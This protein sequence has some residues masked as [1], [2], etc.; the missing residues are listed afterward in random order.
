M[1]ECVYSLSLPVSIVSHWWISLKV[2]SL[3]ETG[4]WAVWYM[5]VSSKVGLYHLEFSCSVLVLFFHCV[6]LEIPNTWWFLFSS[7]CEFLRC[8][9]RVQGSSAS[10]WSCSR[11]LAVV[12]IEYELVAVSWAA[13]L[14][15]WLDCCVCMYMCCLI[16]NA[17]SRTAAGV[18][19]SSLKSSDLFNP[20]SFP[21]CLFTCVD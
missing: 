3:E 9:H 12:R 4:K 2:S 16:S 21:S 19:G 5:T 20:F 6:L 10:L 15:K 8:R 1:Y 18:D 11:L 14:W 13:V 17:N 7:S